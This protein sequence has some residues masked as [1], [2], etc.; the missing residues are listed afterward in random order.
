MSEPLTRNM[1]DYNPDDLILPE[2]KLIQHSGGS[3]AKE[4]GAKPG[5]F[6]IGVIDVIVPGEA[7]FNIILV[8][9]IKERTYWGTTDITNDPPLCSSPNDKLGVSV[10]GDKCTDCQFYNDAPQ[11]LSAEERR[12]KCVPAYNILCFTA[13][14]KTPIIIRAGGLSATPARELQTKMVMNKQIKGEYEKVLLHVGRTEKQSA[15]GPS[16]AYSFSIAGLIE[17]QNDVLENRAQSVILLG[18]QIAPEG[19]Q[20]AEGEQEAVIPSISS[21]PATAQPPA[22][23]VIVEKTEG[24]PPAKAEE[25]AIS[26]AETTPPPPPAVPPAEDAQPA[27]P[28]EGE[29]PAETPV[30]PDIEF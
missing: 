2:V 8:D 5:D 7:G 20:V 27:A 11:A 1:N 4:K 24:P 15:S 28:P 30:P 25:P 19:Q 29:T 26:A 9:I 10:N 23:P 12:T 13:K 14:E 21:V 3:D 6:H 16:F 22:A 18:A 17:D